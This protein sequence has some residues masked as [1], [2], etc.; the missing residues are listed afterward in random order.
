MSLCTLSDASL[1]TV[2]HTVYIVLIQTHPRFH[3]Y[4]IFTSIKFYR[5][6][7]LIYLNGYVLRSLWPS[8]LVLECCPNLTL[9][10]H[11]YRPDLI[12]NSIILRIW[13]ISKCFS[14]TNICILLITTC[15]ASFFNYVLLSIVCFHGFVVGFQLQIFATCKYLQTNRSRRFDF[16]CEWEKISSINTFLTAMQFF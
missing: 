2:Y 13:L 5:V 10:I 7:F 11:C 6:N 12:S 4:Y 9:E 8:I 3:V 1:Q 15:K 16:V 14:T